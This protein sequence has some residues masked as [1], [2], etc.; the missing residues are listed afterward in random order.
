MVYGNNS[1]RY[2]LYTS[3]IFTGSTGLDIILEVLMI[4]ISYH[5]Y[6]YNNDDD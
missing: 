4:M 5:D 3:N 1:Y 2:I 6:N